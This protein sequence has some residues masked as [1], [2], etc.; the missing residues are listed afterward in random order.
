MSLPE[1]RDPVCDECD[2]PLLQDEE[3]L[4]MGWYESG[5]LCYNCELEV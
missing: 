4:E 1:M 3:A 5:P 2:Y